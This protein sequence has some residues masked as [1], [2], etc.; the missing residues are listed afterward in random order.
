MEQ[1]QI[2]KHI[3]LKL[4]KDKTIIY[5]GDEKFMICKS[6]ILSI[7]REQ[8]SD[9]SG[10]NSV[11]DLILGQE[12]TEGMESEEFEISPKDKFWGHCSNLEAWIESDYDTSLLDSSLAFPLL[13]RLTE[14]GVYDAIRVF[15]EEIARRLSTGSYKTQT[16]LIIEGYAEHLNQDEL[17]NGILK[18]AEANI[19][20]SLRF[21][22]NLNYKLIGDFDD[23]DA[24]ERNLMGKIYDDSLLFSV[25]DSS[26]SEL[27]VELTKKNPY[28][29][30]T[31]NDL[32]KLKNLVIFVHRINSGHPIINFDLKALEELTIIT[33]APVKALRLKK[34]N[35]SRVKKIQ[36]KKIERLK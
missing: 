31:I 6:L 34:V 36:I 1:Y 29:I 10:F 27:E 30:S 32:Q 22:T 18:P 16:Y 5:V 26:V 24:R 14:L 19:M 7:L 12:S 28:L 25:T 3:S 35:F 23:D 4:V 33:E 20:S 11:D 8:I 13:K 15:K 2:N 21:K 17:I 9:Y